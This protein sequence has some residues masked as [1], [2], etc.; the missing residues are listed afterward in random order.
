M[1]ITPC[2]PSFLLHACPSAAQPHIPPAIPGAMPKAAAKTK[3]SECTPCDPRFITNPKVRIRPEGKLCIQPKPKKQMRGLNPDTGD[4]GYK[5]C[6][7]YPQASSPVHRIPVPK[8]T[9]LKGSVQQ[10]VVLDSS[11]E[12]AELWVTR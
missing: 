5:A 9:P 8:A 3:D 6:S 2:S 4:T 7:K 1:D 10:A 11:E 12:E